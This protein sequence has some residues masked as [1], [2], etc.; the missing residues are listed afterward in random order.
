MFNG[1]NNITA[2]SRDNSSPLWMNNFFSKQHFSNEI[3]P[4]TNSTLIKSNFY[5]FNFK[6]KERKDL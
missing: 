3:Q 1:I 2:K 4:V 6:N 5:P